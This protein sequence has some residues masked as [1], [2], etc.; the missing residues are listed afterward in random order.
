MR[1]PANSIERARLSLAGL[2]LGDALGERVVGPP[3]RVLPRIEQRELPPAPWRYTDD[4]EMAISIVEVLLERGV[5]DGDELARRFARRYDPDRGY[6]AAAHGLLQAL[7]LGGDWRR[8]AP[9]LFD[10]RGSYGNGGAMRVAPVGA[11]FADAALER[12]AEQAARSAEVTHS[13]PEGIAGAIAVA[14]AAATA[15]QQAAAGELDG[16][17]L[18][19]T[20]TE[21]TP[22]GATADGLKQATTLSAETSSEAAARLLGS[23]SSVSAQDTVP[24]ALWCAARHLGQLEDAFWTTVRGLGDRDTTCAIACGVVALSA[25]VL[26]EAWLSAREQLPLQVAWP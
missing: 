9:A 20:V 18:L 22:P 25:P 1:R 2:S 4:T 8:L 5:V 24:F 14:L 23:G 19:R 11:Y 6:G 12:V 15:W 13:H 17:L 7:R 10:G 3:A 26:P 16:P 21:L